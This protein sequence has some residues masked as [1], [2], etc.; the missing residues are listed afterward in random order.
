MRKAIVLLAIFGLLGGLMF[1]W[2]STESDEPAP[3]TPEVT[4]EDL[5]EIQNE[6]IEI[7][8]D[9]APEQ[10]AKPDLGVEV[11]SEPEVVVEPE[12]LGAI[13]LAVPFTVQSPRQDWVDPLAEGC[14]E[15]SVY[16]VERYYAGERGQLNVDDAEAELLRLTNLSKELHGVWLDTTAEQTAEFAN[17]AY[18]LVEFYVAEDPTLEE[19][20]NELRAG[21]PVI[22]PAAG[23]ELG[24]Q[25]FSG[26]GPLYHM[27]VLRGFEDGHFIAND[28]G[29]RRGEQYL[30]TYETIMSAVGDWNEGDPANGARVF[31]FSRPLDAVR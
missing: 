30:Y 9:P 20:Q 19:I 27:L 16:M 29:T 13:N 21:R 10:D 3:Q 6:P 7:E 11:D 12:A 22:V 2:S 24:N 31:I 14:E 1:F 18:D 26:E 23:R 8:S 17:A 25:F 4:F 15:A 28:P 5:Q